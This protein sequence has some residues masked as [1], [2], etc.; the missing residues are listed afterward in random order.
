MYNNNSLDILIAF[1]NNEYL[2]LIAFI[3]FLTIALTD[4]SLAKRNRQN[5]VLCALLCIS[6]T[7]FAFIDFG[8]TS[9]LIAED[10]TL[11][12]IV[13]TLRHIDRPFILV[14]ATCSF[15]D[16]QIKNKAFY[17]PLV[18]NTLVYCLNIF[19]VDHFTTS[20]STDFFVTPIDYAGIAI[21]LFYCLTF[22]IT[23]LKSRQLNTGK[24]KAVSALVM[25][26]VYPA[27]LSEE[28][29]GRNVLG[30]AVL[31]SILLE[32]E[33][34]TVLRS[35]IQLKYKDELLKSQHDSLLL[36]QI[37][38]HFI[39]NTLNAIY[40]LCQTN[41]QLAGE[42]I[43]TFSDYLRDNL[44]SSTMENNLVTIDEEIEHTHH[45]TDIELLRFPNLIIEYDISDSGYLL[46]PL[47]IQPLVENAIRHGVR[48]QVNGQVTVKAYVKN[49]T[50]FI[51][52]TD[53]GIGFDPLKGNASSS[54]THHEKHSG[55]G[56]K[57]VAERLESLCSGSM[58][59]KSVPG[60]GTSILLT[61]PG[62]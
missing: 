52:I 22:S 46:P 33:I 51:E 23:I 55:I 4:Q 53:N 48:G 2:M 61:I 1:F 39:Y 26:L 27:I 11:K 3:V 16:H 58:E 18:L 49:G 47:S 7:V 15:T 43:L 20:A 12:I 29:V 32:Y 38:P 17:L 57:N 54:K 62:N 6:H 24:L 9:N 40:Y 21:Y 59:I 44:I 28:L 37:Q 60:Q 56:L 19:S 31:M 35:N 5:M 42:T 30:T 41:S 34:F 10:I 50:H 13:S 8:I 45:Y 25:S 14:L 36:S